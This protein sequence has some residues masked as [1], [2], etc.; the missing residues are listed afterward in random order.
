M[1]P[2]TVVVSALASGVAAG[3]RDAGKDLVAS[4]YARL[5]AALSARLSADSGADKMLERHAVDP[6]GY[7]V[8]IRDMIAE[9]GVAQDP[10][11][12]ALARELLA[13]A[14]PEGAQVG[15]YNVRVTGGHGT[16]IGDNAQVNQSFT[17][18]PQP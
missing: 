13:V 3:T 14:D 4:V 9:S 2:V 18:P 5:K 6:V 17:R 12:L 15:K 8:P 11:I 1:D 10:V 16:V 7:L